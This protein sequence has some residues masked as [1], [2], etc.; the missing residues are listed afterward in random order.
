MNA[1]SISHTPASG[2]PGAALHSR[3]IR[4]LVRSA[5]V[6]ISRLFRFRHADVISEGLAGEKQ[7]DA[8]AVEKRAD[9][10]RAVETPALVPRNWQ[11]DELTQA[12]EELA[13]VVGRD[14]IDPEYRFSFGQALEGVGDYKRASGEFFAAL[15]WGMSRKRCG[16]SLDA[17]A[18]GRAIQSGR[19]C[20]SKGRARQDF[21]TWRC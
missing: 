2:Q 12:V 10:G 19:L 15:S 13:K 18:W 16:L 7:A 21:R 5:G 6:R 8:P 14:A 3:S 20:F 1:R 9:D 17:F 4:E 11:G